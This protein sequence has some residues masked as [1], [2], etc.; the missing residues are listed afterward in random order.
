MRTA[1][2][3][4]WMMAIGACWA[5]LFAPPALTVA[6]GGSLSGEMGDQPGAA[7]PA[8]APAA[9]P[10]AAPGVGPAAAKADPRAEAIAPED[11][12]YV[13]E[14]MGQ[15]A[16][17]MN[18]RR[19]IKDGQVHSGTTMQMSI[20][21]GAA[22]VE[23]R[24]SSVFVET[25][26]GK[27]VSMTSRQ[28]FAAMETVEEVAFGADKLTVSSTQGGRRT[29]RTE[30]LPEGEWLT[31]AAAERFLTA[32]MAAGKQEI[33]LRTLDPSLGL[34]PVS[35]T[36]KIV[37]RENV[38]VLGKTVP[39]IKWKVSMD[40]LAGVESTEFADERGRAVRSEMS[41]GGLSVVQMLADKDLAM[42]PV[43][44]P[45][46][47]VSTLVKPDRPLPNARG[48]R[49]AEYL[50]S[51]KE[52]TLPDLPGV[53]PTGGVPR[54][55]RIDERTGRVVV[56][57]DKTADAA[58]EQTEAAAAMARSRMIDGTDPAVKD[59]L[60]KAGGARQAG[61]S[62]QAVTERLRQ[63][64]YRSIS[65]KNMSVGF[66]TAGET[67]RTLEGDCTEHAVLLAAVLRAAGLPARAVTGL[68]YVEQAEGARDVFGFHMW[69]QAL[70]A[71]P[72]GKRR[73]V[74]FDAT[75][76]GGTRYDAAHIALG[77]SALGDDDT[78][79]A[80]VATAPLLG[81]MVITVVRPAK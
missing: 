57:L 17:W 15:R 68:I 39:A 36:R 42:A 49:Q 53:G 79:N 47:L 71:A 12:W 33:T 51:V 75:L 35:I 40:R 56:D 81:R 73:W 7:A 45:E 2:L 18:A 29:E 54:F 52:G 48:L 46:L 11:R 28:K 76:P 72:D 1:K 64:V 74:D 31:P 21:R 44:G 65:A 9:V 59:L 58:G 62:D 55:E 8:A 24:V 3:S 19:E 66:A 20:Q 78:T 67:A 34:K 4:G 10:A 41:V 14:L 32:E 6:A 77:H 16:G 38:R 23:V 63:F 27:P 50:V 69:T 70:I 43:S 80:L 26:D 13:L 5:G 60:T 61:E 30:P 25:L 22:G 37:G